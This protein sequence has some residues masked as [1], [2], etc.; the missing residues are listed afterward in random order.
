M[1]VATRNLREEMNE[2]KNEIMLIEK[3][4]EEL[5]KVSFK[6]IFIIL[7]SND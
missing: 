3:E 5:K 1:K 4:K 2:V 7:E 6:I